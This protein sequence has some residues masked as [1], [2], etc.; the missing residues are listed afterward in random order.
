[1]HGLGRHPSL[2]HI[3]VILSSEVGVQQGDPLGPLLFS[4]AL[5]KLILSIHND[6]SCTDLRLNVWYLDDGVLAGHPTSVSRALDIIQSDGPPL[7]FH[8]NLKKCELFSSSDTSLFPTSIPSS[9]IPNFEPLGVPIGDTAFCSSFIARKCSSPSALLSHLEDI[10]SS[11]P[12][13]A[14]SLLRHC[15]SFCKLIHLARGTPSKSAVEALKDFD[16][17]VANC[18]TKC[19]GLDLSV[20][21]WKQAQLSPRRGG[22]GLRPLSLHALAAFISSLCSSESATPLHPHLTAQSFYFYSTTVFH[23]L[24]L[25]QSTLCCPTH[26]PSQRH[27]SDVIEDSQFT[28]LYNSMYC[29]NKARLLSVFSPHAS[30]CISVVPSEVMGL[31]LNSFFEACRLASLSVRLEAGGG[32]G[33]DKALTRPADVLVSN[34]SG[35]ASAAYDITVTSPLNPSIILEAGVSPGS[36]AKAAELS[37]PLL[38]SSAMLVSNVSHSDRHNKNQEEEKENGHAH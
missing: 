20:D 14:L 28:S 17:A 10:E 9:N 31:H 7:G 29:A 24:K 37:L 25:Y 3:M 5:Q 1:M 8:V 21:A 30:A 12:H 19:T 36:A 2:W 22:L 16:L 26:A 38:H 15:A 6:K 13:V 35:S 11:D 27:L 23:S 34:P 4:A 18:F 32:L 33:K